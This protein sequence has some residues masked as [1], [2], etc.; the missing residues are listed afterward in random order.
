MLKDEH[1]K[2]VLI[3]KFQPFIARAGGGIFLRKTRERLLGTR[4]VTGRDRTKNDF[5]YDVRNRVENAL[6]DLELFIQASD[7]EQVHQVITRESLEPVITSLLRGYSVSSQRE[8]DSTLGEI[9]DMLIHW[10]FDYWKIWAPESMTL[11]HS[12]TIDE[13]E[14]LSRYLLRTIKGRGC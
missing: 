14:D 6:V 8:N 1:V 2:Q 4:T 11:S 12:R 3:A 5:S 13:A 10:A 7:R 9:A